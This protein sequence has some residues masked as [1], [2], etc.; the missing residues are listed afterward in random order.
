V[1]DSEDL[2]AFFQLMT[3]SR[4]LCDPQTPR[5]VHCSAGVGRTGTFIAL[6]HLL[7]ELDHGGLVRDPESA[8]QPLPPHGSGSI[9]LSPSPP[10]PPS[11]PPLAWDPVFATVDALRTQRRQ[12][13][14]AVVQ[15]AFVYSVVRTRWLERYAGHLGRRVTGE[16]GEPAPKRLGVV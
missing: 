16:G 7:R 1:P 6:E 14:Q 11:P 9:A 8:T 15:F 3:L 10:R 13:V 12:M 4:D 2:D 5:V